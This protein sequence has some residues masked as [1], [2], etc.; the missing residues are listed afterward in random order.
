MQSYILNWRI[1]VNAKKNSHD[2]VFFLFLFVLV[3]CTNV[4]GGLPNRTV[5][6]TKMGLRAKKFTNYQRQSYWR[7]CGLITEPHDNT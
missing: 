5:F 4:G 7:V 1:Y 6:P 3:P 2:V